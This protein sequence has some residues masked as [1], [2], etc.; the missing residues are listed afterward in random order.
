MRDPF[1]ARNVITTPTGERRSTL[2]RRVGDGILLI[3]R[4]RLAVVR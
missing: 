3:R 1:H 2:T 4:A